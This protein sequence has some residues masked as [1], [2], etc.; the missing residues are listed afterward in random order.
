MKIAITGK[1]GVGKT[2][3]TALLAKTY[4]EEGYKV[5]AIDADPDANLASVLGV[6]EPDG[7]VPIVEMKELIKE[8]V[9]STSEDI[10]SYFTMNPRVDDIPE[11]YGIRIGDIRL[12]VLGHIPKARGG[13]ACPENI[14]L[15]ELVS[16]ALTQKGEIVLIDMEAG[17]EHL[18]RGTAQG[19]DVMIIVVEPSRQSIET[20]KRIF[21]LARELGVPKIVGVVNR[22]AS[23][24]ENTLVQNALENIPLIASISNDD[25]IR[26]NSI[27]NQSIVVNDTMKLSIAEITGELKAFS[28]SETEI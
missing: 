27:N 9:G 19:V 23:P 2:T 11:K 16:H 13:C 6:P 4:E 18:G 10:G 28:A 15:R 3:L 1:G 22:V 12:L 5:Y 24:D 25:D 7:I 17:I 14:F 26:T 21:K 20:S 8:R